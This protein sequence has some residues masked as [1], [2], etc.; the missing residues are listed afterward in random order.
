MALYRESVGNY[1]SLSKLFPNLTDFNPYFFGNSFGL[2]AAARAAGVYT[3]EVGEL[4]VV[5]RADLIRQDEE[6]R[7]AEGK[8]RT[9]MA[10]VLGQRIDEIKALV[11]RKSEHY[12]AILLGSG[13]NE[14]AELHHTN[15]NGPTNHVVSGD[16]PF[17]EALVTYFGDRRAQLLPI[18]AMYHAKSKKRVSE[19]YAR[20]IDKLGIKFADPKGPM[21]SSTCPRILTRGAEVKGELVTQIYEQVDLLQVADLMQAV[22]IGVIVDPGPGQFANQIFKRNNPDLR[23]LSYDSDLKPGSPIDA[24]IEAARSFVSNLRNPPGS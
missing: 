20:E 13:N 24:A 21:I 17:L 8:N 22:Q 5:T 10:V 4:L 3:D 14:P 2:Y 11:A 12:R 15:T 16:I 9:G 23:V 18:D 6:K 1:D 19:Q 7:V